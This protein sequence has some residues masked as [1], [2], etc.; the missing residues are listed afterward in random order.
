MTPQ[1]RDSS[2]SSSSISGGG[3]KGFEEQ[4]IFVIDA[5]HTPKFKYNDVRKSYDVIPTS[6]SLHGHAKDKREAFVH[7]F[8]TVYQRLLRQKQ[9]R[10]PENRFEKHRNYIQLTLTRSLHGE[11]NEQRVVFGLLSCIQ[12]GKYVLEDL[13]SYVKL[14]LSETKI[15]TG[16]FTEN[17]FVLVEGRLEDEVFI[18]SSMS[19][20]P[21]ET[22]KQSL[23]MYPS[24]SSFGI[25]LKNTDRVRLEASVKNGEMDD[26]TV[27]VLSDLWLDKPYILDNFRTLLEGFVDSVPRLFV[28]MGNFTSRPLGLKGGDVKKLQAYFDDLADIILEFPD[29]IKSSKFV[30]IPGPNDLGIGNV[31]P[32]SGLPRVITRKLRSNRFPRNSTIF[33]S[34]PC[35]ILYGTR[36]LLFF[37]QDITHQMRRNCILQPSTHETKD[38]TNHLVKT[39]LEQSHLCP[40]PNTTR[41]VHW[42]NEHALHVY[43]LPDLLVLGDSVDQFNWSH[44]ECSCANPASFALDRSFIIYHP[45]KNKVQFS[46]VGREVESKKNL[47]L[48]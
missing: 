17:C 15:D 39:I 25:N 10:P 16:L 44:Y 31:L 4:S 24:M 5:I 6:T 28:L 35:R 30:F 34:N 22:R 26:H 20:P 13:D 23:L 3:D 36:E 46:R 1:N 48:K 43:P 38:I 18:V 27:V 9:F 19:F 7:R 47:E 33:P 37:R 32:R 40:L 8:H 11:S 29:L 21:A 45:G 14:D 41:P 2:A 12:E 42:E